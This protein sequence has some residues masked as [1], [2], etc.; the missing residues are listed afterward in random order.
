MKL[1]CRAEMQGPAQHAHAEAA[2]TVLRPPGLDLAEKAGQGGWEGC[3]RL[4]QPPQ[5]EKEGSKLRCSLAQIGHS[6]GACKTGALLLKGAR[7]R[8]SVLKLVA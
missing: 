3:P 6:L 8:R 7:P 2:P 1:Q 4:R 5:H